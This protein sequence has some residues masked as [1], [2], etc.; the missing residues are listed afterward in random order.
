M[1]YLDQGNVHFYYIDTLKTI[2]KISMS[3]ASLNETYK[4]AVCI[5]IV[6]KALFLKYP[7]QSVSGLGYRKFQFKID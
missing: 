5:K 4:K 6:I 3:L 2:P 1:T 7:W